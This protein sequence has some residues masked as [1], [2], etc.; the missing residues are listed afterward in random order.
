MNYRFAAARPDTTA[1]HQEFTFTM[2][3]YRTNSEDS[4]EPESTCSLWVGHRSLRTRYGGPF[5]RR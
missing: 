3:M 5:D 4:S 1:Q 2:S